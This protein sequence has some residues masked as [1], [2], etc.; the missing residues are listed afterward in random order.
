MLSSRTIYWQGH[1]VNAT[2]NQTHTTLSRLPISIEGANATFTNAAIPV[3]IGLGQ[4]SL[5]GNDTVYSLQPNGTITIP[6]RLIGTVKTI[7]GNIAQCQPIAS[8][9]QAYQPGQFPLSAVDGAVSTKWQPTQAN[10]S[11]SITVELPEPFVPITSIHFDWAQS[12]PDSYSVTF[13]NSTDSSAAG[14]VNVTSSSDVAISNAYDVATAAVI[15]PYTSNTTNVTLDTPVY[16]GRYATL[17]ITGNQANA[18][19]INALNGSGA[20]VA[21]FAIVAADGVDLAKRQTRVWVA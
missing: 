8:T 3:T 16:S 5:S 7:P 10:I 17:T 4:D 13:S 20:T 11:S 12:P 18:G 9:S 1:A 2:S 6:N 21:E 15:A 14:S 19:T